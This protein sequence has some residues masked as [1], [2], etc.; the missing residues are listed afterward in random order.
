MLTSAN[1]VA[2]ALD[3]TDVASERMRQ[4]AGRLLPG[5]R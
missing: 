3:W 1:R 5:R 4:R 2:D